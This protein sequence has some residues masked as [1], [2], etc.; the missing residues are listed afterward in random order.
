[1]TPRVLLFVAS[2]F[3]AGYL[4]AA[5]GTWGSLVALPIHWLLSRLS[6]AGYGIALAVVVAVGMASAGAAEKILDRPDPGVVVIDE[7]AGMLVAL[8]PFEPGLVTWVA[9]FLLFRCFDI[10]KPFPVGWLDSRL[11]G[12]LGIM[13]DDLAAGVY[14]AA[15]LWLLLRLLGTAG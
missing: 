5:P 13:A 2:G 9:G 4:P 14:A 1:M 12:G 10:L 6:P 8:A 7:I 3:G 11:H 15:C